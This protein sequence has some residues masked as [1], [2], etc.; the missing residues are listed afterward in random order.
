MIEILRQAVG[1]FY[2]L[3]CLLPLAGCSSTFT[4]TNSSS[5]D[6]Q[7]EV[8]IAV[9]EAVQSRLGSLPL[10]ERRVGTV[11]A[12][13]QVA[14]YPEISGRVVTV[15]AKN[16]D[17]VRSGDPLVILDDSQFRE[18]LKQA[19]ASLRVNQ[20]SLSQAKARYKELEAEY[21]RTAMLAEEGLASQLEVET[22]QA[23]IDSAMATIELAEAQIEESKSVIEEMKTVLS[24]T[25]VRAPITGTIGRRNA[26][27]GMQVDGSTQLYTIGNLDQLRVEVVLTSEALNNVRVGQPVKIYTGTASSPGRTFEARLSRISPFLDPVTRSTEAEIDIRNEGNLLRPGMS[28]TAEIL[29]GESQETTLLPSSA[30][31]THPNTGEVGVYL[32]PSFEPSTDLP[33]G[34]STEI[35]TASSPQRAEFIPIEVV[36]EGGMVVGVSGLEPDLWVVAVGQNLLAEGREEARVRPSSWERVM[37]LQSLQREDLLQEVLKS[38]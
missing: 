12:Q 17:F 34:D 38:E 22:L 19:E 1:R 9:V 23:Q 27:V 15:L 6:P 33:G 4:Q 26:E 37:K 16:G 32:L 30:L 2:I 13:N 10:S 18:Q 28:V 35:P 7:P 31:Y 24:K 11:I 5:A 3:L 25:E 29:Y 20:A 8:A 36:A 21:R 14:L